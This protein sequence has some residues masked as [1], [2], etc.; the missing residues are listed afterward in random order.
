MNRFQSPSS[1]ALARISTRI[2]GYGVP[3]RDLGVERP[4]RLELD[5][6][7]VLVHERANPVAQLLDLRA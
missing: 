1:R 6:V 3:G 5:R 4:H 2:S 7:D